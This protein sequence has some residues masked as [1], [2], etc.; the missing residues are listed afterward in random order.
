M[1]PVLRERGRAV[2]TR[3]FDPLEGE[4]TEQVQAVTEIRFEKWTLADLKAYQPNQ[5]DY[6]AGRGFLRRGAGTLLGGYT[7]QGKSVLV[8]QIAV[9]VAAGLPILGCIRVPTPRRVMLL[10]AENDAD[11]LKRDIE[12]IVDHLGADRDMVQRNLVIHHAF[13]IS[14]P[15]LN[16]YLKQELEKSEADLLIIDPYQSFVGDAEMNSTASFLGWIP[17]VE[18][19]TRESRMALLLVAHFGKPSEARSGWAPGQSVYMTTGTSAISNWARCSAEL[20][21]LKG[22]GRFRLRF[23]KNPERTGLIDEHTG[24]TIRDLY[25]E[26]SPSKHR[27]YW[28]VS[29][30]QSGN[31]TE[32]KAVKVIQARTANPEW[33]QQQ[34]ASFVG[35]SKS[36]V[37]ETLK[38]V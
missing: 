29:E 9:S 35:C 31:E 4:A 37:S 38:N 23:G 13:G 27:P 10:E 16:A 26:H 18:A 14:G 25:L 24:A 11:T 22:E 32:T 17:W 7:G 1:V 3:V 36:Y 2:S 20:Y 12:S 15:T 8:E 28:I 30:D 6:V 5:A 21:P 34:I 19:V 33:T